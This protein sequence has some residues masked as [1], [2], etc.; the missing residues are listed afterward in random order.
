MS[1]NELWVFPGKTTVP[2]HHID[3]RA[4]LFLVEQDRCKVFYHSK[5]G[6]VHSNKEYLNEEWLEV[7][8][9]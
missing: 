3:K 6:L 7:T 8:L 1:V 9:I 5:E 4:I 2:V